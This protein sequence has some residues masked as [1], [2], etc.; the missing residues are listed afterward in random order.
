MNAI[1]SYENLLSEYPNHSLTSNAEMALANLLVAQAK[2]SG[3]G[4]ILTPDRSGSTVGGLSEVI[5]QN[6][7]PEK[8]RIVFS[9]PESHVEELSACS[10]CIN[11]SIIGPA[12][13]PE[14]GPIGRYMLTPGQYD[15]VVESIS[16]SGTTAWTG[17][18][19][20]ISGDEYYSYFIIVTSFGP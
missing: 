5:I 14:K 6:D 19:N 16:D 1:S 15:V 3:A 8:L 10:T 13:C 11:Y 17:D 4:E 7:S 9:G 12:F 18:W 20:L 2:E